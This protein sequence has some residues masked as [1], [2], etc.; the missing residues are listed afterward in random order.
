MHSVKLSG[1]KVGQSTQ[2]YLDIQEIRDNVILLKDG[3]LRA[4]IMVS[5]MNFALKSEDEQT[6]V[7]QGYIQFLNSFDF[8][9]QIVIQSR[10]L[11]I[12]EYLA[13]LKQSEKEQTNDLLRIQIAG[14]RQYIVELIEMAEIMSKR[15]YVVVPYS[16]VSNKRKKFFA[17]LKETLAPT[18]TVHLKQKKFAKYCVEMTKRIDY[19]VE[20]LSSIGLKTTQ[21]DT[22]SLI[23]LFYNTYNPGV[24]DTQ[25][26]TE[27]QKLQVEDTEAAEEEE[28]KEK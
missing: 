26:L 13:R 24:E 7:I 8:P 23:E 4:A 21:L 15:F 6:A 3:T 12:D 1:Q 20:G 2:K 11:N 25:K 28:E 18:S 9:L 19:V 17:R 16:P 10:K 5:S 14:Y 27:L 22:Q